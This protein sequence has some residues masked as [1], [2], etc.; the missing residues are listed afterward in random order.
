[1]PFR[2]PVPLSHIRGFALALLIASLPGCDSDPSGASSEVKLSAGSAS[3][4][5]M[6]SITGLPAS[7]DDV[8]I[9]VGNAEAYVTFDPAT[10]SHRFIVPA[11]ARGRTVVRIPASATGEGD[12]ERT[13]QVQPLAYT[14]GSPAAAE[15]LLNGMLAEMQ[16]DAST[17]MAALDPQAEPE[18]AALVAGMLESTTEL[19]TLLPTLEPE[20][21]R[22]LLAMYSSNREIFDGVSAAFAREA[23]G[24]AEGGAAEW[25][26]IL[27]DLPLDDG[28]GDAPRQ[29][30]PLPGAESLSTTCRAA[31]RDLELYSDMLDAA[32][33]FQFALPTLLVTL[34]RDPRLAAGVG[35]TI[36]TFVVALNSAVL[37]QSL[38][39]VYFAPEGLRLEPDRIRIREDG[40]TGELRAYLHMVNARGAMSDALGMGEAVADYQKYYEGLDDA[41]R[42]AKKAAL[43]RALREAGQEV[44]LRLLEET[45]ERLDELYLDEAPLAGG[46]IPISMDGLEIIDVNNSNLWRFTSPPTGPARSFQT[47]GQIRRE[48]GYEIVALSATA[49]RG[50]ACRA[51][52][53]P[54]HPQ[55]GLNGFVVT[56]PPILRNASTELVSLNSCPT[57]YGMASEYRVRVE[58]F[59][60]NTM[61]IG[62][63]VDVTWSFPDGT[64]GSY[65]VAN[66]SNSSLGSQGHFTFG[67]CARFAHT[68]STTIRF[69]ATD[70][71]G[72]E[73][74]V[75]TQT[76][77][78][79]AGAYL[80][81]PGASGKAAGA[82]G[83]PGVPTLEPA[84]L[85]GPSQR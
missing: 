21:R 17:F 57:I 55:D 13:L 35:L 81:L 25:S 24:K 2:S 45:F 26:G 12:I 4:L 63:R 16:T 3:P 1:M 19:A 29:T 56:G 39:P 43:W 10:T 32:A 52:T 64:T 58:Y 5:E 75:L 8:T 67:Y 62:S 59:A 23:A 22:T 20:S 6:M 69:F 53:A 80:M 40:G 34:T 54:G 76:M 71:E 47:I 31:N 73:S 72:L 82:V 70:P 74:N 84:E 14:G 79:P 44:V 30:A 46:E 18:L 65:H 38:K 66:Q 49:G 28:A 27:L 33:Y 61:G 36:N 50:E 37:L 48:L 77:S 83:G 78:K 15:T 60:A 7:V 51:K 9:T 41:R 42:L 11:E 85:D 68:E